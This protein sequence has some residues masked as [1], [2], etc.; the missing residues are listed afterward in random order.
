MKRSVVYFVRCLIHDWH[1]L[2]ANF[3]HRRGPFF[4]SFLWFR[5]S[6]ASDVWSF[7]VTLYEI[8][9]L[10][11]TP[12]PGMSNQQV[13]REVVGHKKIELTEQMTALAGPIFK[14]CLQFEPQDRPT[15]AELYNDLDALML[16]L[17]S[18]AT[19]TQG[20]GAERNP[21]SHPQVIEDTDSGK[22]RSSCSSSNWAKSFEDKETVLSRSTSTKIVGGRS[23]DF[24]VV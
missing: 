16:R 1:L 24:S 7:G 5:Y 12:F 3:S 23:I 20:L 13:V 19:A 21:L 8:L 14:Q 4:V 22:A 15:F 17:E 18:A 9:S 10:G 6:Q 2:A 11:V